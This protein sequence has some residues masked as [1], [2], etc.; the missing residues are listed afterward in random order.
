MFKK[1][2]QPTEGEMLREQYNDALDALELAKQNFEN[3]DPDFFE[4]ANQELNL[5]QMQV[6][7]IAKKMKKCSEVPSFKVIVAE[8]AP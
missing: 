5:A 6:D 4:I 2:K 1:N 7:V 8:Y 3:A